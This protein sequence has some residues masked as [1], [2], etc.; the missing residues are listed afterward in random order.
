MSDV[1]MSDLFLSKSLM[2]DAGSLIPD[3]L[4]HTPSTL[5]L[6]PHLR[7]L[8]SD[9]MISDLFLRKSLMAEVGCLMLDCLRP[10]PSTLQLITYAFFLN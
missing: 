6:I 1:M 10:I 4:R 5:Q 2:A 8:M 7:C 9:V 3:C